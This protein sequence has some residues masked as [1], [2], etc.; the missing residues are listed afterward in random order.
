VTAA[1]DL[2]KRTCAAQNLPEKVTDPAILAQVA[3]LLD[4]VRDRDRAAGP[5][6]CKDVS[7]AASARR[8]LRAG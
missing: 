7:R 1:A 5:G 6:P 3:A 4:P 2:V 8:R